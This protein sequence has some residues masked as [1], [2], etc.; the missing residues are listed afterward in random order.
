MD[1]LG[2]AARPARQNDGSYV[3]TL[4]VKQTY[5]DDGTECVFIGA[6]LFATSDATNYSDYAEL[7]VYADGSDDISSGNSSWVVEPYVNPETSEPVKDVY[8]LTITF[9][10]EVMEAFEGA[11]WAATPVI[12][13]VDVYVSQYVPSMEFESPFDFLTTVW[14]EGSIPAKPEE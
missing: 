13:G 5:L 7:Y 3:V 6:C 11:P 1:V 8:K 10:A 12:F 4:Y 2:L 9:S 14:G